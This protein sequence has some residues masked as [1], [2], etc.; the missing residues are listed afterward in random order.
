MKLARIVTVLAL[1]LGAAWWAVQHW[2]I[3]PDSVLMP[4]PARLGKLELPPAVPAYLGVQVHVD[5]AGLSRF[6]TA[7]TPKRVGIASQRIWQEPARQIYNR[8]TGH[9]QT[10]PGSPMFGHGEIVRSAPVSVRAE[11]A[12]LIASTVLDVFYNVTMKRLRTSANSALEV[13]A[14][15]DY[16]I[17]KDWHPA[18][19]ITPS[20]MWTKPPTGR[21]FTAENVNYGAPVRSVINARVDELVRVLPGRA[22]TGLPLEGLMKTLWSVALDAFALPQTGLW[23]DLAPTAAY[24]Q[25]PVEVDGGL[26]FDLGIAAQVR[27]ADAAPARTAALPPLPPP[28]REIPDSRKLRLPVPARLDYTELASQWQVALMASPI[29]LNGGSMTVREVAV[30][31]AAP[32][33]VLALRV[34]ANVPGRYLWMEPRGW[35]YLTATPRYDATNRALVLDGMTLNTT[36]GNSAAQALAAALQGSGIDQIAQRTTLPLSNTIGLAIKSANQLL[37]YGVEGTL[38]ETLRARQ[39]GLA[40][41]ILRLDVTGELQPVRGQ[42]TLAAA[43]DALWLFHP[44]AGDARIEVTLNP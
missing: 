11:G 44:V 29:V 26:R 16:D 7:Q 6:A 9:L 4:Q 10:V 39:P 38:V 8:S 15:V 32:A 3:L 36:H 24:L 14:R 25:P 18:V 17:G 1:L 40:G 41:V 19:S 28:L 5:A 20:Y 33:L 12:S 30:F 23:V 27:L 37:N 22:A 42:V 21:F 2:Q 31:P 35:I 43:D 13:K 34:E